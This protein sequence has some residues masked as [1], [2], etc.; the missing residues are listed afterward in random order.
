MSAWT[1]TDAQISQFAEDSTR[2]DEFTLGPMCRG[3]CYL[4]DFWHGVHFVLTGK[5]GEAGLPLS[6]LVTGDVIYPAVADP[7][8]AIFSATTGSLAD[9]LQTLSEADLR[10]NFDLEE[11]VKARV[12]P[13]RPWLFPES[14][15]ST[16]DELMFYFERLRGI[17]LRAAGENKGLLFRRYEDL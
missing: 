4:A 6:V 15:E 7:T 16:F 3:E 12:Y 10:K 17:A 14:S 2:L 9:V 5:A 13:V 11:M 8:H 1:V